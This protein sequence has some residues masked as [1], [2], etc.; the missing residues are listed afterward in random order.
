[1]LATTDSGG[2]INV[3][4]GSTVLDVEHEILRWRQHLAPILRLLENGEPLAPDWPSDEMLRRTYVWG[5]PH[6]GLLKQ[7]P[8]GAQQTP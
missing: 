3:E 5:F 8:Q 4:N 7:P 1:L 6:L 2:V